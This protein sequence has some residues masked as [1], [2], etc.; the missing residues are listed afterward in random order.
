MRREPEQRDLRSSRR[1]APQIG[2]SPRPQKDQRPGGGPGVETRVRLASLTVTLRSREAAKPRWHTR[3]A[4][5]PPPDGVRRPP[6]LPQ[7]SRLECSEWACGPSSLSRLDG[8]RCGPYHRSVHVNTVAL[9]M[10]HSSCHIIGIS[11]ADG[12]RK[13]HL[14]NETDRCALPRLLPSWIGGLRQDD[15]KSL[16]GCVRG[17]GASLPLT[18]GRAVR[19][20]TPGAGAC[21]SASPLV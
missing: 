14:D 3:R 12:V 2:P 20:A 19:C 7:P 18:S 15:L 9:D 5:S 8:F 21:C 10:V 6:H 13:H 16:P 11:L 1:F 17:C 4:H